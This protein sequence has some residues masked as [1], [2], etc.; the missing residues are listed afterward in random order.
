MT[1][2][3]ALDI[4]PILLFKRPGERKR[5]KMTEFEEIRVKKEKKERYIKNMLK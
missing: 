4:F 1:A 3:G 5:Q 2:V